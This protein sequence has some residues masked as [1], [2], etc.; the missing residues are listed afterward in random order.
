MTYTI[1][2]GDGR[3]YGP[4]PAETVIQWLQARRADAATRIRPEGAT[5]WTTIGALPE[6]AAALQQP[7]PVPPLPSAPA[8]PASV[9]VA[10]VVPE[11]GA[12]P[13]PDDVW[14]RDY[15]LDFGGC[16]GNAWALLTGPRM[17]TVIGGAAVFLAIQI[18][19]SIFAQIPLIGLVFSAASLVISGA[20]TGGLYSFMLRCVR[21]QPAEV[22]DVFDGF[23]Y[24][25]GQLFL[26]NLV[27]GLIACATALPGGAMIG[28]GAYLVSKEIAIPGAIALIA[29]G[30]IAMIIP[31]IYLTV[32]W[33]FTLPLIMDKRLEFWS[34]MKLSRQVVRKHWWLM[35]AF[36]LVV[37]LLSG[38]GVFACL[39][40]LFFTIPLGT[41][42]L[43]YA[44]ETL[45][46]P[47]RVEGGP[48]AQSARQL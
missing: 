38:L 30:V 16:I 14:D 28:A 13:L 18:G 26:G 6:F 25:F 24:C 40:G 17:W 43:C 36:T 34:A 48:A 1:I 2:G 11:S 9:A 20:L 33:A 42:A 8:L 22:G 19:I 10:P 44:Y 21:G 45:F 23:R 46:G 15:A 37:G 31:L 27:V 32:C 29:V 39:V 47:R 4:V 12:S 7:P 3:E 41:A 5:D 35:F